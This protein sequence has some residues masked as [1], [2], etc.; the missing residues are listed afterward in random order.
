MIRSTF[1]IG[2]IVL[3]G[4][5]GRV[6]GGVAFVTADHTMQGIGGVEIPRIH[7]PGKPGVLRSV[8]QRVEAG[9]CTLEVTF[10]AETYDGLVAA[11]RAV[12]AQASTSA[13]VVIRETVGGVVRAAR[14]YLTGVTEASPDLTVAEHML[15]VVYSFTIPGGVWDEEG[16]EPVTLPGVPGTYHVETGSAPRARMVIELH[17]SGAVDFQMASG[18]TSI[19][20]VSK[21]VT[22]V[23]ELQPHLALARDMHGSKWQR[24]VNLRV[25]FG[26]M[27]A[28]QPHGDINIQRAQGVDHIVLHAGRSW[29]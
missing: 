2:D 20:F 7:I 29:Y 4:K 21:N 23:I 22:D 28:I 12:E 15:S 3:D 9:S 16:A 24:N 6:P 19:C 8:G 10:I 26:S 13:G 11:R 25:P 5:R 1:A 14:C 17:C 27:F 18:Y